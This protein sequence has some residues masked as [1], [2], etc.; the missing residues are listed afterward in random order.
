MEIRKDTKEYADAL[1]VSGKL[2]EAAKIYEALGDASG[3]E[4]FYDRAGTLYIQG[5][6]RGLGESVIFNKAEAIRNERR[7]RCPPKVKRKRTLCG[8]L[9]RL[10]FGNL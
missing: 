3:E 1:V 8:E 10:V 2:V 5:G 6:E 7:K 9:V 4:H